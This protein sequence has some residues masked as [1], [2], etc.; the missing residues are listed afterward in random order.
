MP[1]AKPNE[2]M[3][4][5]TF[6]HSP[7]P[8]SVLVLYEVFVSHAYLVVPRLGTHLRQKETSNSFK[9]VTSL[10]VCYRNIAP[11]IMTYKGLLATLSV[12][13]CRMMLDKLCCGRISRGPLARIPISCPID[14]MP[15]FLLKHVESLLGNQCGVHILPDPRRSHSVLPV[16]P[17]GISSRKPV[18]LTDEY[19][20]GSMPRIGYQV[21]L[22]QR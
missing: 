9:Y 7:R 12:P 13:V 22:V 11:G 3:N 5:Q 2:A 21:K 10:H 16:R 1:R 19:S 4:G 8:Y 14:H 6:S 15:S 18:R 20:V 17:P